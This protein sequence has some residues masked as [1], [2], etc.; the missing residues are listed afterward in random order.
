MPSNPVAER[1]EWIVEARLP[2]RHVE[3]ARSTDLRRS[4]PVKV[5]NNDASNREARLLE[6][7][8]YLES[9]LAVTPVLLRAAGAV[10]VTASPE[11]L[12]RIS[13]HPLVKRIEPNRRRPGG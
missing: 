1:T 5:S 12:D 2:T 6:L 8:A 3:F 4:V 9:I 7:F 13:S 11:E 10:S